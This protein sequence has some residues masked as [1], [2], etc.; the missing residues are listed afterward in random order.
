MF[1]WYIFGGVAA[2]VLIA[3]IIFLVLHFIKKKKIE[4]SE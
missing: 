1:G 4:E 2:V 3:L